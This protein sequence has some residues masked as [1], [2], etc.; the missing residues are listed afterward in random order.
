MTASARTSG[1]PPRQPRGLVGRIFQWT[2]GVV[3]AVAAALVL[4]VVIE[5]GGL[6][7]FWA[8]QGA[9]RSAGV[10]RQD[11]AWLAGVDT[12]PI[13]LPL[14]T[15]PA[16]S[17]LAAEISAGIYHAVF[18]WT[19]I[20]QV[21]AWLS[22]SSAVLA[23]YLE[24]GL[25]AVQTFFVRLA[26]TITALPLFLVF[27]WWGAMEGLVRRDLRRFGGDIERGMIYHWAKHVAG[28]TLAVPVFLYLAWPGSINPAWLFVPFTLALGVNLMVVTST[29]TKYV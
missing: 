16:P 10:L 6:T 13:I 27:A 3:G 9:A 11:L 25:N 12:D 14:V 24:A 19:G 26:I 18:V 29:F 21:L 22:T 17:V 23:V 20:G 7:F 1:S 5:W 15:L 2:L 28:A 8:D 4:A